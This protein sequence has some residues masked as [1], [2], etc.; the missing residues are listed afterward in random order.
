MRD[1]IVFLHI[2]EQREG[3]SICKQTFHHNRGRVLYVAYY[4]NNWTRLKEGAIKM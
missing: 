4:C 1:G 2:M 3:N